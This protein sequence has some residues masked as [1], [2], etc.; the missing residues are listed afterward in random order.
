SVYPPSSFLHAIVIEESSATSLLGFAFQNGVGALTRYSRVNLQPT[1]S[2]TLPAGALEDF[3]MSSRYAL[4]L[5]FW[6]GDGLALIGTEAAV[7]THT[8]GLT[9]IPP[10]PLPTPST[11]ALGA[12][13]L[14]VPEAALVFDSA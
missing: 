1:A 4:D 12:I 13:H 9:A 6:T 8:A 7:F 11:D 14:A 3:L 10:P 5:Q 2:G